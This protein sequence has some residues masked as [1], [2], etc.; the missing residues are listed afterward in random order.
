MTPAPNA[1]SRLI[2]MVYEDAPVT[3]FHRRVGAV[4][5]V[6]ARCAG[7]NGTGAVGSTAGFLKL[8]MKDQGDVPAAL[9]ALTRQ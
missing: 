9:V 1:L 2:W 5:P 8:Q 4:V 6:R 3:A 7:L